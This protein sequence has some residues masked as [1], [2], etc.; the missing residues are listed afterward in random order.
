MPWFAAEAYMYRC[1]LDIT[2]YYDSES[3]FHQYDP[4]LLQKEGKLFVF[5]SI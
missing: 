1:L 4:F 5:L 3:P 2:K